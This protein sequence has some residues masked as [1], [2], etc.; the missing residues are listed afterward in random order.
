MRKKGGK[1]SYDDTVV[2]GRDTKGGKYYM[3]GAVEIQF[4]EDVD[5]DFFALVNGY[6][7]ITPLHLD[8]TNYMSIGE[9]RDWEL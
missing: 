3:I 4:E 6:V 7:S 1:R 5:S 9:L 2:E 8:L